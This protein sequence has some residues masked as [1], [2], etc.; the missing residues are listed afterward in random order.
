MVDKLWFSADHHLGH[1][2]VRL[3]SKCPF[4]SVKE[5]DEALASAWN[6]VIGEHDL[7]YYLGDF[8]LGG[9]TSF[10][11]YVTGLNGR[12]VFLDIPWHHDRRWLDDINRSWCGEQ[13][14]KV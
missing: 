3:Y 10:E 14:Y 6:G 2:N 13:W 5:M 12:K 9:A 7:V 11:Y 1:D 4:G 8:T